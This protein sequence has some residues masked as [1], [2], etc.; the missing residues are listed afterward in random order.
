MSAEKGRKWGT[1][2]YSKWD[3]LEETTTIEKQSIQPT[4]FT[5]GSSVPEA[6]G[7]LELKNYYTKEDV[8]RLSNIDATNEVWALDVLPLRFF[9]SSGMVSKRTGEMVAARPLVIMLSSLYPIGRLIEYRLCK[10]SAEP[11]KMPTPE[12]VAKLII[13]AVL[14]PQDKGAQRRPSKVVFTSSGL[15]HWCKTSLKEIVIEPC[16]V[17]NMADG[18]GE[19]IKEISK[20]MVQDGKADRDESTAE[21]KSM[22]SKYGKDKARAF[23]EVYK[24]MLEKKPW[25]TMNERQCFRVEGAG[26]DGRPI[27][28]ASVGSG[29]GGSDGLFGVAVFRSRMDL[30]KRMAGGKGVW[31]PQPRCARGRERNGVDGVKLK[32]CKPPLFD[33]VTGEELVFSSGAAQKEVWGKVKKTKGEL[34]ERDEG[35]GKGKDWWGESEM[36]VL[37]KH[38]T[39]VPFDELD[40]IDLE[41]YEVADREDGAGGR[42]DC[43]YPSI[44][45][46]SKGS[47]GE[48]GEED[49]WAGY[50]A[51][52][53]VLDACTR[54]LGE[55]GKI[56]WE[57]S[58]R[59]GGEDMVVEPT[60]ESVEGGAVK[61][62]GEERALKY[63]YEPVWMEE[64][65]EKVV[66][67]VKRAAV[68]MEKGKDEGEEGEG[69]EEGGGEEAVKE[70]EVEVEVGEEEG[71]GGG[72]GSGCVVC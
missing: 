52:K 19:Y 34:K 68:D 62:G 47:L 44:A 50:V 26:K 1:D 24:E 35:V 6:E 45:K 38:I 59:V 29:Q 22:D 71:G 15:Y 9:S 14:N 42:E 65:V 64:E 70:E 67:K 56:K 54:G 16:W 41:G 57:T 2:T 48:G 51:G 11:H 21:L 31:R 4:T 69:E 10:N 49:L 53:V 17:E 63:I 18:L 46:V 36:S 58:K 5:L 33:M 61:W 39:N 3:N 23:Y 7:E 37:Y 12:E 28:V 8:K 60:F 72:G 13:E 20:K 55:V 30:E 25:G 27:W 32:R 66:E 43:V 40:S